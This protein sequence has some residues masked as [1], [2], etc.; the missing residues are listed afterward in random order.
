MPHM[1]AAN[2]LK[3][4]ELSS[5]T[6]HAVHTALLR[7][8]TMTRYER[9][10]DTVVLKLPPPV[11]GAVVFTDKSVTGFGVRVTARGVRTFVLTYG[12]ERRR[13]SI[14]RVG[15]ISL[16]EARSEAKRYLASET[17]GKRSCRSVR[18]QAGVDEYLEEVERNRKERTHKDYK[19]F[20]ARFDFPGLLTD[21]HPQDIARKLGKLDKTPT[22]KLH[23]FAVLRQFFNWAYRKH[24]VETSPMAR[25][26]QPKTPASRE[27]VLTDE[28]LGKVW[29]ACG[30]DNFGRLVKCLV[31]TGQR[32]GEL[33][34]GEKFVEGE[35][36]VI[37]A[38]LAKN[39]REHRVP[40]TPLARELLE[41]GTTWGG[42]SKSKVALDK[43][44]GVTGWSLHDLRR[45][46]ASGLAAQGVALPTIERLLNHVS[47]SFRG[48]VS[49]Y[50]RYDFQPEMRESLERW[51]KKVLTLAD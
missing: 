45:T 37:P 7:F 29:R 28:E 49:V 20:L 43:A 33:S 24:Y 22:T 47:G 31:L 13:I 23:A 21:I 9:L 36:L 3:P 46:F 17:L 15:R 25:M 6:A 38:S 30:E 27:R 4:L 12:R 18:W 32:R 26:Q 11:K 5:H 50:Q 44:S 48:I 39:G 41:K 35:V 40:L 10:T 2:P 42:F 14:G 19:D 8:E 1:G 51:E 34:S 16:S